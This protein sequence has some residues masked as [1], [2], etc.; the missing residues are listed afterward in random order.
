MEDIPLIIKVTLSTAPIDRVNVFNLLIIHN[1]KL[2]TTTIEASL[3]MSDQ[4]A[5]RT[6]TELKAI[7]LVDLSK[8]ITSNH[9]LEIN[10]K[11]TFKLFL[12]E[13]FAKLREGFIPTDN[14][15]A[16]EEEDERRQKEKSLKE[17]LPPSAEQQQETKPIAKAECPKCG[18][19]IDP[20]WMRIHRC[21][22]TD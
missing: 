10:L 14:S 13:E 5:R 2:T 11:D 7:E 8:S 15:Q 6:M 18:E 12:T 16:M 1:G 21:E 19:K 17:K 9:K 3:N 4:T 20:Y 22:G